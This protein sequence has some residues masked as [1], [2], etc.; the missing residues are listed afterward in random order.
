MDAKNIETMIQ[1]F[2]WE[3]LQKMYECAHSSIIGF[4]STEWISLSLKKNSLL[5]GAPS[6]ITGKG[7]SGQKNADILLCKGDNPSIPV[8]VETQVAK[9]EDNLDSLNVMIVTYA[10]RIALWI[11][12][13]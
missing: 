7:R 1:E 6:P 4:I 3:I 9:Y 13:F 10:K 12:I 2:R 8:E 5:D 11:L